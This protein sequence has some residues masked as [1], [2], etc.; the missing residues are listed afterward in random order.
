MHNCSWHVGI[1]EQ[2]YYEGYAQN[3]IEEVLSGVGRAMP[4]ARTCLSGVCS[5][6]RRL[7]YHGRGRSSAG[8]FGCS[9]VD[10]A[11]VY[12]G[13]SF[14]D[15]ARVSITYGYFRRRPLP[16][17]TRDILFLQTLIGR[18]HRDCCSYDVLHI[19]PGGRDHYPCI[20]HAMGYIDL[21]P[22]LLAC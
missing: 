12:F 17:Y 10:Y 5:I 20:Q 16:I 8:N 21:L 15:C 7:H 19:G 2:D 22:S 1:H 9:F 14:V 11:R 18:L 3:N 6:V 4:I 13:C